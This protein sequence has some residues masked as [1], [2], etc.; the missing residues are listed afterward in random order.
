MRL[1]LLVHPADVVFGME[2]RG[3]VFLEE[4]PNR[5]AGHPAQNFT[6]QE[7]LV[8]NVVGRAGTRLPQRL[9]HFERTDVCVVIVE[10]A[11]IHGVGGQ[12]RNRRGVIE[13]H[14]H[15]DGLLA[16]LRELGP[17][18]RHGHVGIDQPAVDR[19]V[20][21][22]AGNAF[23]DAHHAHRG[24][25]VPRLTVVGAGPPA[26]QV[27]HGLAIN[28][29]RAACAELFLDTKVLGERLEHRRELFVAHAVQRE[30][31]SARVDRLV[32]IQVVQIS[33]SRS[34]SLCDSNARYC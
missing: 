24:V 5:G 20:E 28:D 11:G 26:P 33:L 8:V 4:G 9:L 31:A 27:D 30:R 10:P 18:M 19:H 14:P 17:V 3:D 15:R 34:A 29:D 1:L 2:R 16:R 22:D 25:R 12:H 7:A 6:E 32:E 23:G 13:H 21:A